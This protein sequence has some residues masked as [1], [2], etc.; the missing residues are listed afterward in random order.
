MG[1]AGRRVV[2]DY[3]LRLKELPPRDWVAGYAN[4]VMAYIPVPGS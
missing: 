1:R 3:A 4:D 2:I